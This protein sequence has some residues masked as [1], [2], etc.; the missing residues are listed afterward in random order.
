MKQPRKPTREEKEL[1]SK[2]KLDAKN[3]MVL[4]EDKESITFIHKTSK[5]T[6]KIE[7]PI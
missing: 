6:R 4:S 5:N 2:K 7:K 1:L 3:W